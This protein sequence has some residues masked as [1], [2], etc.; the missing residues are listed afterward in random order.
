MTVP[1]TNVSFSSIQT[2]F[3]GT[4]PIV[5]SE[6]YR[7]GTFVNIGVQ[8]SVIDGTPIATSGTIRVGEFRGTSAITF[9]VDG[10]S[11][12]NYAQGASGGSSSCF[13]DFN[14]DGTIS[15]GGVGTVQVG[16]YVGPAT[17]ISPS[18]G[19]PGN[20]YDILTVSTTSSVTPTSSSF[21]TVGTWFSL[22]TNRTYSIS[23]SGSQGPDREFVIHIRDSSTLSVV[24]NFTMRLDNENT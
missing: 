14:Q 23:N 19:T 9:P 13:I 11:L 22:S 16:P 5:F 1:T 15:H 10:A 24:A 3:G 2:E 12:T 17:W 4:N 20:N 18:G 7:G 8:T 21:P 6:Y